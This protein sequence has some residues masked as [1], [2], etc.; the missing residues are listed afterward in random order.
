MVAC[1]GCDGDGAGCCWWWLAGFV[2]AVVGDGD[3]TLPVVAV[4]GS[5]SVLPFG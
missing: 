5:R 4:G 3:G 2:V 1:G